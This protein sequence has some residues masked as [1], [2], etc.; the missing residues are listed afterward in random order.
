MLIGNHP[1][2]KKSFYKLSPENCISTIKDYYNGLIIEVFLYFSIAKSMRGKSISP[3]KL[4]L[5]DKYILDHESHYWTVCGCPAGQYLGNRGKKLSQIFERKLHRN[6]L[7]LKLKK[8]C[9]L[10]LQLVFLIKTNFYRSF[11]YKL[12]SQMRNFKLK[13]KLTIRFEDVQEMFRKLYIKSSL[14]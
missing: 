9:I 6:D 2:H 14:M 12:V 8:T 11:D 13:F 4:N 1:L 5:K 3:S 7:S 10:L